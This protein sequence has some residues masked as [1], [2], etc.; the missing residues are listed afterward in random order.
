MKTPKKPSKEQS[1]P[2]QDEA[3]RINVLQEKLLSE[4]RTFGDSLSDVRERVSRMEPKLDHL[5]GRVDVMESAVRYHSNVIN[6]NTE[7]IRGV[8]S[9]LKNINQRLNVVETKVAS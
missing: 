9:D 8:Q 1:F 3:R 7:A 5:S 2:S 6:A 4:F